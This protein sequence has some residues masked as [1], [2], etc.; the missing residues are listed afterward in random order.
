[1]EKMLI[2]IFLLHSAKKGNRTCHGL[3]DVLNV[4][5]QKVEQFHG[6]DHM[7]D[8]IYIKGLYSISMVSMELK[9]W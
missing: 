8:V 6:V 3:Q 1:M 5:R 4:T 7:V 9:G 2:D